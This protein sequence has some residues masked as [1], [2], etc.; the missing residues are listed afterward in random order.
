MVIRVNDTY[1]I[2]S[3]SRSWV[4]QRFRGVREDTSK[5]DWRPVTYHVDFRSALVSLAEYR[6]RAIDNQATVDE[7]RETL[8]VIRKEALT[9]ADIFQ[10]LRP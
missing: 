10:E 4:V 3:D 7:I 2:E 8:R 5:E 9:A 1:R 6:I